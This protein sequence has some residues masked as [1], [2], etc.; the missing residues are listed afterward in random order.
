MQ[1]T[2][3]YIIVGIA[4][5]AAIAVGVLSLMQFSTEEYALDVDAF[6]DQADLF[7]SGR[8][9]LTNTGRS[10]LTNVVVDFGTEKVKLPSLAPGQKQMVSTPS[11]APLDSVT[12]TTDEG[13]HIVKEYRTAQRIP[14]M[15][16][17]MG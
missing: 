17:G 4:A 10:T 1:F 9:I 11:D 15:I 2:Q 14:G 12:V 8:V 3:V 6:K 5:A 13:I 16:G 7:L